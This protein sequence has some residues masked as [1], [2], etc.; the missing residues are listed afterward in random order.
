[1]TH[2]GTIPGA[3]QR[4]K[5]SVCCHGNHTHCI[6]CKQR[7]VLFVTQTCSALDIGSSATGPALPA[8]RKSVSMNYAVD[9]TFCD[10]QAT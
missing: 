7:Q 9:S 1:M 5:Y 3:L 4:V 8:N 2:A 10:L 6:C